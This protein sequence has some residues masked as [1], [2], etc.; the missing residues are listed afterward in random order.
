MQIS[1][2]SYKYEEQEVQKTKYNNAT[3]FLISFVVRGTLI[4]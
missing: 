2:K 1:V 3:N 4:A